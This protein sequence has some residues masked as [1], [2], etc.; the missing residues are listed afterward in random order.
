MRSDL[1]RRKSY[2]SQALRDLQGTPPSVPIAAAAGLL[3]PDAIAAETEVAVL[4]N[5][6]AVEEWLAGAIRY[7][8]TVPGVN[9]AGA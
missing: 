9:S 8:Y 6:R 7:G 1:P 2:Y 3:D 4:M 5:A